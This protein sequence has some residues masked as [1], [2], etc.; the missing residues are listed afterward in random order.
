MH[1]TRTNQ[2]TQ[3]TSRFQWP[4]PREIALIAA[5]TALPYLLAAILVAL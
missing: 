5:S 1:T 4:G 3:D 2:A